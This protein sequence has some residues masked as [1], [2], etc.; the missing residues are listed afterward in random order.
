[1]P[2][3]KEFFISPPFSKRDLAIKITD[4]Q[5]PSVSSSEVQTRLLGEPNGQA[6]PSF[7]ENQYRFYTIVRQ[8]GI[9]LNSPPKISK[10]V[11]ERRNDILKRK[12]EEGEDFESIARAYG[13]F[14]PW[15]KIQFRLGLNMLWDK[16][17]EEV[18]MEFPRETL[19]PNSVDGLRQAIK[20][21]E[22]N[23]VAQ[24]QRDDLNKEELQALMAKV[25]PKFYKRHQDL[26]VTVFQLA[27][28]TG[29]KLRSERAKHWPFIAKLLVGVL[30]TEGVVVGRCNGAIPI[31]SKQDY[32][33]SMD[34]LATSKE[35]EELLGSID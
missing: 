15:V 1:M 8:Q 30:E 4:G 32:K 35:V 28:D 23:L 19:I 29:F 18:Q 2:T 11:L 21:K 25:G 14:Q 22:D 7:E 27:R 20:E 5:K 13:R 31:V 12:I 9:H 26:F 3:P 10:R 16:S 6:K 24:L 33:D 34:I 17:P